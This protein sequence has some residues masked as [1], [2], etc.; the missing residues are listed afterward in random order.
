[1]VGL[2]AL[3]SASQTGRYWHQELQTNSRL[4][5]WDPL[6]ASASIIHP[7]LAPSLDVDCCIHSSIACS[8]IRVISLDRLVLLKEAVVTR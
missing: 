5:D 1:M 8:F 2:E 7:E 4:S 3:C 6:C